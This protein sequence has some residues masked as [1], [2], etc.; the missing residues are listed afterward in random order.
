MV[1]WG[2]QG[3]VSELINSFLIVNLIEREPMH[4]GVFEVWACKSV[5]FV[6]GKC[7]FWVEFGLVCICE[8]F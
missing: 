6:G 2:L 3:S 4:G 8:R 5:K 1:S 7:L